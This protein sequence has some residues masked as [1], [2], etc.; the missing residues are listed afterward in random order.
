VQA[1]LAQQEQ[2]LALATEGGAAPLRAQLASRTEEL[3]KLSKKYT[4]EVT[5]LRAGATLSPF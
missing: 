4:E 3:E 2:Q 5:S 1:R